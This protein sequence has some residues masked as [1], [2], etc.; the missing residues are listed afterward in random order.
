MVFHSQG[1]LMLICIY[2]LGSLTLLNWVSTIIV[3]FAICRPFEYN[4]NKFTIVGKCGD[5]SA[6]YLSTGIVN[7]IIDVMIVA[8]PLPTLWNLHMALSRR[9]SLMVIFSLRA[10]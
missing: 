8:L 7:L 1:R 10:L 5:T 3:A 6:Y 9:L 2:T 4:W